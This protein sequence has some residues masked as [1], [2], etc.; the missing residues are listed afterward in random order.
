LFIKC[1][2]LLL[3]SFCRNSKVALNLFQVTKD[4]H[5]VIF[6]DD[7]IIIDD[8]GLHNARRIGQLGFSR[9]SLPLN[10]SNFCDDLFV[11]GIT[12]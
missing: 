2:S 4:G 12:Q 5:A 1:L 11:S 10:R 7:Y 9:L 6:H 8:K 3:S